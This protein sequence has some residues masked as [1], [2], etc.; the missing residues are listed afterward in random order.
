MSDEPAPEWVWQGFYG[1]METARAAYDTLVIGHDLGALVP[2]E[3]GPMP[4]D[5]DGI[6]GM[7]AV[8]TR[9]AQPMPTPPG[10]RAA[11]ADMVSRMVGA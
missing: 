6:D 8:M 5:E 11:R 3:T 2:L 4:V 10:L 7:F 9:P 1:P